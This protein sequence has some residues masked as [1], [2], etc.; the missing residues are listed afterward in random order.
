VSA[1]QQT[2]KDGCTE[3]SSLTAQ[4]KKVQHLQ[5]FQ[6]KR[7]RSEAIK[8]IPFNQHGAGHFIIRLSKSRSVCCVASTFGRVAQSQHISVEQLWIAELTIN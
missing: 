7:S 1:L 2:S 8:D 3:D 4:E 6:S 5:A